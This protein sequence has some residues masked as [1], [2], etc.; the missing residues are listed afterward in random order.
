MV[1]A[2]KRIARKH[3]KKKAVKRSAGKRTKRSKRSKKQ[4]LNA[5]KKIL[6]TERMKLTSE[7][8]SIAQDALKSQK[9]ASGDLS[10]Y[11]YHMADLASDSYE[12]EFTLGIASEEQKRIYAID[13]ALRRISEGNYGDCLSCGRRIAKK[14]LKAIPQTELCIE[15]QKTKEANR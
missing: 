7:L 1:K 10:G 5:Y 2:K 9:D 14:R 4:E 15:C 12:R 13:E 11:T 3:V 8:S 6:I